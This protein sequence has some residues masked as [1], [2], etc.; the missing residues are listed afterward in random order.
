MTF[1]KASVFE[2]HMAIKLFLYETYKIKLKRFFEIIIKVYLIMSY[3]PTPF[4]LIMPEVP[5][6]MSD[7][8]VAKLWYTVN[9]K[10][11][12]KGLANIRSIQMEP[13]MRDHVRY[14]RVTIH[15]DDFEGALGHYG[16]SFREQIRNG[17]YM[18]Y[19]ATFYISSNITY[20]SYLLPCEILNPVRTDYSHV[21]A[22]QLQDVVKKQADHI[23]RLEAQLI[24][25][26]TN[27]NRGLC[28]QAEQMECLENRIK[29]METTIREGTEIQLDIQQTYTAT[30]ERLESRLLE[31]DSYRTRLEA[32]M[33]YLQ[34]LHFEDMKQHIEE[35]EELKQKIEALTGWCSQ[36]V[37]K[38]TTSFVLPKEPEDRFVSEF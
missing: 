17:E 13:F 2:Y 27:N 23:N 38:R 6:H 19:M 7:G 20:S 34:E 12:E 28:H 1:H 29:E 9:K 15:F 8:D 26:E 30:F 4:S 24:E 33:T 37:W 31:Q 21:V 11:N 18:K 5:A 16:V 14:N 3:Q 10:N 36:P 32:R 22:L 35:K 25:I